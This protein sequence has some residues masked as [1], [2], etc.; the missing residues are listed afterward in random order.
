MRKI[1][2]NLV[3]NTEVIVSS[4]LI[5]IAAVYFVEYQKILVNTIEWEDEFETIVVSKMIASGKTLYS[6]VFSQHGPFVF[7]PG[8]ILEFIGDFKHQGY[9]VFIA[10]M[11][12]AALASIFFSPIFSRKI[13]ATLYT[14]IA[15]AVIAV[16][17]PRHFGHMFL[18]H[19]FGGIFLVIIFSQ[20]TL[21]A[22][23]KPESLNRT[24]TILGNILIACLP[25]LSIAYS[26]MALCLFLASLRK[27][28]WKNAFASIFTC[29][30]ANVLFIL[31]IS[32]IAGYLAIHIYL[33][34]VIYTSLPHIS[35]GGLI[36]AY[37]LIMELGANRISDFMVLVVALFALSAAA[38]QEQRFPWRSLLIVLGLASVMI[39]GDGHTGLPY[40]YSCLAMP[41]LFFLNTEGYD[42]RRLVVL[43][44]V[45]AVCLVKL[46]LTLPGING[47]LKRAQIPNTSEF[48]ELAKILT[49]EEDRI[50][51]YSFRNKEYLLADRLP[52]SGHIYYLPQQD[53]Y[54]KDPLFNVMIDACK[55]I[56]EYKPKVM[57]INKWKAWGRFPW[58]NY[59]SCIQETVDSFYVQVTERPYYIRSDILSDFLEENF[60]P[61][62]SITL[63]QIMSHKID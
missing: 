57:S 10:I 61:G 34:L 58:E 30:V 59:G 39:R 23:V 51:S 2:N 35:Q 55:E 15:A 62:D 8:L 49:S 9:R 56:S 18:Y 5:L 3:S 13:L 21:P 22:I 60:N 48:G 32:S 31:L 11:Q 47:T 42:L 6:E 45:A 43:C 36:G 19:T 27:Q 53:I 54:N 7:F 12:L 17:L 26:P 38:L 28:Y 44:F 33:N 52:A 24:R 37:H 50:I 14:V 16:Y 46:S 41:V 40:Y 20:Y 1:F 4:V 29:A 63:D 25:F